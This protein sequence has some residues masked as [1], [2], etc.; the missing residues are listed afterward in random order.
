MD[1]LGRANSEREVMRRQVFAEAF[2]EAHECTMEEA[3]E[4]YE[5]I[6]PLHENAFREL[7]KA[8]GAPSDFVGD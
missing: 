3:M 7:A 1:S 5:R 8:H 6:R 4:I 2:P